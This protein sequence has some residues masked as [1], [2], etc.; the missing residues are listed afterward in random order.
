MKLGE[1]GLIVMKIHSNQYHYQGGQSK[2]RL[3]FMRYLYQIQ[4]SVNMRGLLNKVSIRVKVL[5]GL[6]EE[7]QLQ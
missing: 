4:I 6:S 7:I 5:L 3:I 1:K 2:N